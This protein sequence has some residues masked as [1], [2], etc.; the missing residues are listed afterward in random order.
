MTVLELNMHGQQDTVHCGSGDVCVG[1]GG[2]GLFVTR[3]RK[4]YLPKTL[5]EPQVGMASKWG[6]AP[7]DGV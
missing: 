2:E 5:V 1:G 7:I 3:Q 4:L 6:N